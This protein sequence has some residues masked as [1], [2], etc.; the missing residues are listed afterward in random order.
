VHAAA[1]SYKNDKGLKSMAKHPLGE[2]FGFPID[3]DSD[4]AN[5]HRKSHLCPYNNNVPNCTK[6]KANDPLGVCSV[7][8]DAAKGPTA[9]CPVRFR[10]GWSIAADASE[11]FFPEGTNWTSLTEVKLRDAD[12]RAAGNIDL[13]LVSYDDRGRIMDFGSV[14]VQAVY[15]S[16]NIRRPFEAYMEDPASNANLDWSRQSLYPRPD[17]LSSSRKRLVPQLMYKGSILREWDKKQAVVLDRAFMNTL[18]ALP[19]VPKEDADLAWFVYDF[20][21]DDTGRYRMVL[22]EVVYTSFAT[23]MLKVSNTTAGPVGDFIG[24]LQEKL[25]EKLEPLGV[26]LQLITEVEGEPWGS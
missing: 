1:L 7:L 15:I 19:T 10:E 14:E 25:D 6:D 22:D 8:F 4:E 26:E 20:V 23:S 12:G 9:T 24:K 21:K 3:D 18:P 13:V 16:G 5:R 17:F 2:V 11:F